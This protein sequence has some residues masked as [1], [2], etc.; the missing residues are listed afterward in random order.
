MIPY[1]FLSATGP[2][3]MLPR[4]SALFSRLASRDPD[5]PVLFP[6]QSIWMP[7]AALPEPSKIESTI[8]GLELVDWISNTPSCFQFR[9]ETIKWI[10]DRLSDSELATKDDTLGAIITLTM[11]EVSF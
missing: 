2:V 8:L 11:W 4:T 3:L 10:Q 9:L 7:K 1:T 6:R 5:S